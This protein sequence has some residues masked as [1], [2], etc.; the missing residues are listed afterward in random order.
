MSDKVKVSGI[1]ATAEILP[2]LVDGPV[3]I[4]FA[5]SGGT[6]PAVEMAIDILSGNNVY[7]DSYKIPIYP[8]T[9]ENI[10]SYYDLVMNSGLYMLGQLQPYENPIFQ[11]I[12]GTYPE[13]DA[14]IDMIP[15]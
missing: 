1:N 5:V 15:R 2:Y 4:T 7:A 8:I 10:G 3:D 9:P 11:A 6:F 14:L 12:T 13:I